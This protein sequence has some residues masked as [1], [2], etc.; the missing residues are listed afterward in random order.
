MSGL[1]T[2]LDLAPDLIVCA[3]CEATTHAPEI[4]VPGEW[5][6][7]WSAT[8]GWLFTCPACLDAIENIYR[9]GGGHAGR[10]SKPVAAQTAMKAMKEN[11]AML[12]AREA[13]VLDLL[14]ANHARGLVFAAAT[15]LPPGLR[16]VVPNLRKKGVLATDRYIPIGA[17]LI[18][19]TPLQ[20]MTPEIGP[21]LLRGKS[22]ENAIEQ[23]QCPGCDCFRPSFLIAETKKGWRCDGCILHFRRHGRA[24]EIE[25]G[26]VP[27]LGKLT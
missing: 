3:D 20:D 19:Q 4:G 15:Q 5:D 13:Q 18:G 9:A 27:I 10:C 16:Q 11:A 12:T 24:A 6:A 7:G 14:R 8:R 26:G 21:A 1:A 22:R 25:D 17:G 23:F 2:L